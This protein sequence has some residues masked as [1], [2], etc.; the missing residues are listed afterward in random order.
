MTIKMEALVEYAKQHRNE[1]GPFGIARFVEHQ[2]R[3]QSPIKM[4]GVFEFYQLCLYKKTVDFFASEALVEPKYRKHRLAFP[5]KA[6]ADGMLELLRQ[7]PRVHHDRPENMKVSIIGPMSDKIIRDLE[8]GR[9]Y[10]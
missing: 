10:L 1:E 7:Y 4:L 2:D 9:G 3:K 5:T 6:A 8:E